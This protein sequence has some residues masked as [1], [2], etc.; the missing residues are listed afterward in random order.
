MI[1]AYSTVIQHASITERD[2]L[3]A[4]VCGESMSEISTKAL[5]DLSSL[6]MQSSMRYDYRPSASES[7]V[8]EK[9]SAGA[10]PMIVR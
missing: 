6:L 7:A 8:D 9:V 10:G 2:K 5:C 4:S 3:A 1:R